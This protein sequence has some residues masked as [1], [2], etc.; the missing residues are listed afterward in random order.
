M[1][2]F[3]VLRRL[4]SAKQYAEKKKEQTKKREEGPEEVR[5]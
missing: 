1:C 3:F 2:V 4:R 5:A